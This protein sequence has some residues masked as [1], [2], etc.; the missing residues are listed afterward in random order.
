[1]KLITAPALPSLAR[2][3][4]DRP[5]RSLT[6]GVVQMHWQ[7][8]ADAHTAALAEGV[9]QAAVW[10][11]GSD[12]Q[13]IWTTPTVRVRPARSE[14]TRAREGSAGA[15]MSFMILPSGLRAVAG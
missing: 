9:R 8:D 12:C 13:C 10:A 1:M 3:G 7:C 4:P 2:V 15:V 11:S 6:V 5:G 14:P